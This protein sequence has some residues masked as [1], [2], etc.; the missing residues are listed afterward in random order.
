MI[1]TSPNHFI[2][3][4]GQTCAIC[5]RGGAIADLQ[6]AFGNPSLYDKHKPLHGIY[7]DQK[8]YK[9]NITHVIFDSSNLRDRWKANKQTKWI[10]RSNR[11]VGVNFA[12]KYIDVDLWSESN[13]IVLF[14]SKTAKTNQFKYFEIYRQLKPISFVNAYSIENDCIRI[15][16]LISLNITEPLK[17]VR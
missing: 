7:S 8:T 17:D 16:M 2:W 14:N 15:N 6:H 13:P 9:H 1:A 11:M 5:A 10:R 4:V 3:L 12:S